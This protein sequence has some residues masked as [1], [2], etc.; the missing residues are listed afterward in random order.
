MDDSSAMRALIRR[1]LAPL[2][3]TFE[4]AEN[5]RAALDLAARFAPDLITLDLDMPVLD[6]YQTCED[7]KSREQTLHIPVLVIS[8]HPSDTDRLRALAAGAIDYYVKPFSE[9]SLRGLVRDFF[10][11]SAERSQVRVCVV[12]SVG[13]ARRAMVHLLENFG[14][15]TIVYDTA[16]SARVGL[17]GGVCELLVLDLDLPDFA[18]LSLLQDLRR[19]PAFERLPV[20]GL[21][22]SAARRDLTVAFHLGVTDLLRKPF[23]PEEFLA[24]V[25][26]QLRV[27]SLEK[28]LR[29]EATTDGLTG[30][31]NRRELERLAQVEVSRARRDRKPLG[32]LL[33]D[34]DH[35]KSVNDS[36]GHAAGDEV[37]RRVGRELFKRVRTTDIV[38]RYGGEEFAVLLPQ[39]LATGV[40]Y[41]AERIRLAIETLEYEIDG[42][43]FAR[44]VSLG[45]TSWAP[46]QL[47]EGAPLDALFRVAD[48]AL[49]Q[50][51]QGGR[52]RASIVDTSGKPID[53]SRR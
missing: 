39:A 35:F 13:S 11:R 32:V 4:E 41:V 12:E 51:K 48:D 34:I 15:S 16:D 23:F 25:E 53:T 42:A 38:A 46:D 8:A 9:G 19:Q 47:N 17:R 28:R 43:R 44:T 22:G 45:G 29:V 20:V 52:N 40:G 6:G 18:G 3:V 37:L 2:G 21:T 33:A 27:T 31:Y 1:E 26:N 5:G 7:L 24:R 49:Y 36:Y 10:T 50:S 30:L 14:Y